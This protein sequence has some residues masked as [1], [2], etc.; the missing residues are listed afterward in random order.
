MTGL[1]G[2]AMSTVTSQPMSLV[3]IDFQE[4]YERH[5]CRHSQFGINVAHLIALFG[6]WFGV[7]GLAYCLVQQEWVPIVLAGI[8]LAVLLPNLPLRV[9]PAM[10]V[11]LGLFLG[12]L[13]WL[14]FLPFWAYLLMIPVFYK[15]Q[16]WSH[17][18]FTVER[19]MTEFN[20]KY[21]KGRVLF[22]VLLFYEVPLVLNYLIFDRRAGAT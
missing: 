18:I 2:K 17:K 8:Y 1:G 22:V 10:V 7:Y 15:A 4:L 13:F 21:T 20:K 11:F 12:A 16:S 3:T 9:L 19:D 14:P 6:T 5:L